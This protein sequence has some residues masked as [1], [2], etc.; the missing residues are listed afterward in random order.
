MADTADGLC[1]GVRS[2]SAEQESGLKQTTRG[3]DRGTPDVPLAVRSPHIE[4]EV[5][6]DLFNNE[7][8]LDGHVHDG[9]A[10][11]FLAGFGIRDREIERIDCTVDSGNCGQDIGSVAGTVQ[12][13]LRVYHPV[14]PAELGAIDR[15]NKLLGNLTGTLPVLPEEHVPPAT[16]DSS[17]SSTPYDSPPAAESAVGVAVLFASW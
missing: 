11:T 5:G 12:G 16:E 14:S 13:A 2:H 8:N 10:I 1:T 7:V 3:S 9:L 4:R 17:Q 15:D 6:V